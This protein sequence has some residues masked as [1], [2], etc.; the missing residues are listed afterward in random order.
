MNAEL[1]KKIDRAI[2]L[3]KAAEKKAAEVGQPVEICYSGGKDSEVI[4]ELAKMAGI[5]YRAIY[6]N[7]TIDPPGTISHVLSKGVEMVRPKITFVELMKKKGWP[8]RQ[9][10]F[11]CSELKEYKILD[12]AVV[13]IRR[14]ESRKRAERYHEPEI[15]R[16]YN[17]KEKTRQ[18]LPILDWTL[19]DVVDF[20][21]ER[22]IQC[23]PHYY[24]ADGAFHPERRLGCMGCP[25]MSR[26]QRIREFERHPNMVKLYLRAGQHYRENHFMQKNRQYFHNIYEWFVFSLFC[27]SINEFRIRFG[28]NLFNGGVDCKEFLENYF[29]IKL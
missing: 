5:N 23:A 1:K 10:R 20:L 16:V 17:A 29:H 12:Y 11:C 26:K 9:V 6:K 4:L 22:D 25:M 28:P 14:E 15:C 21:K 3:L 19:Q 24:D 13:G 8:S 2:R 18:Y 7:T 27:E